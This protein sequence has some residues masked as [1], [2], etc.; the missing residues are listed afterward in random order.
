[1]SFLRT[2]NSFLKK[3]FLFN[4][5]LKPNNRLFKINVCSFSNLNKLPN[6]SNKNEKISSIENKL[7][8]SIKEEKENENRDSNKNDIN[9]Y[10]EYIT[11]R[12]Y[13]PKAETVSL[14]MRFFEKLNFKYIRYL[15]FFNQF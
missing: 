7:F 12:D 2:S 10:I 6:D 3:N 1:M 5:F 4:K 14:K 11:K 13:K 8:E 15:N 9:S